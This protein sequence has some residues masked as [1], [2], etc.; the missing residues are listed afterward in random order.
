MAQGDIEINVEAT[1]V[2]AYERDMARASRATTQATGQMNTGFGRVQS[3][4]GSA[5]GGIGKM[6]AGAGLAFVAAEVL[7]LGKSAAQSAIAYETLSVQFGVFLGSAEKATD[8]LGKLNQFSIETPFTPDQVNAAG[9]SLLAFGFTAEQLI[10][11]MK[12][13]GDVSAAVGKDFNELSTIYGKART[14]GTLYAE[15]INQLTEAGIP[16]IEELSK[17]MGVQADEVKKLGS[18]GKLH[19]AD[20]EK[21]FANMTGKGGRF[22]GMMDKMSQSTAGLLSTIEGKLQ[23][24]LRAI[25][26]AMLPTIK[27]IA[28]GFEPAFKSVKAAVIEIYTPMADAISAFGSIF[29]AFGMASE[30]GNQFANI[31]GTVMKV[32][33]F[34]TIPAQLAWKLI[35]FVARAFAS[36]V[37]GIKDFVS[38]SPILMGAIDKLLIPFRYLGDAIGWV[39]DKLG[40][41]GGGT[42]TAMEQY[43]ATMK[44]AGKEVL[45]LGQ[46][47]GLTIPEIQGFTKQIDL[48][49]YAGLSQA[50][51]TVRMAGDMRNYALVA[52]ATAAATGGVTDSVDKLSGAMAKAAGP[53]A[54]SI[55]ALNAKLSELKKAFT[56]TGS[57]LDRIKL[58]GQIEQVEFQLAKFG[59]VVD[60]IGP[61]VQE[62]SGLMKDASELP[63]RS[64]DSLGAAFD[65]A[66]MTG[67]LDATASKFKAFALT[68]ADTFAGLKD[69]IKSMAIDMGYTISEAI[70]YAITAGGGFGDAIKAVLREMAVQIPKMAGMALLNAAT[71]PGN[72]AI[73]LPLTIAGA[74]LLG[75]S[76]ILSGV[77]KGA[78]AKK[79]Q[80]QQS[81][82]NNSGA[83]SVPR[84]A[85]SGLAAFVDNQQNVGQQVVDALNGTQL[86]LQVGEKSMDAYVKGANKRNATREGK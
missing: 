34:V 30:G 77:F 18:Q 31:V 78:D 19:F 44:Y 53:A 37:S 3:S 64:M 66:A 86:T 33:K 21:A 13:V 85:Q 65:P 32:L 72:S 46:A 5:F 7:N 71:F 76:G 22:S 16:I 52:R 28:E 36:A 2:S 26:L 59:N 73:A 67:E 79:Q 24:E 68:V 29:E 62:I 84:A 38:N 55:D 56:A 54:G 14:A 39:G 58:G 81:I 20:L 25:G 23:D 17:V 63:M 9:R 80:E 69:G 12:M 1:G 61:K 51:A 60:A 74:A 57:E 41:G 11:T 83:S 40:I 43:T 42:I 47:N 45:K 27:T 35:G 8:V 49:R 6:I 50:E 75:L 70:G 10:P 48:S 4:M 15:D 82:A